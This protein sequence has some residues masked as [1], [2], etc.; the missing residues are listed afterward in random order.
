MCG[1]FRTLQNIAK[2]VVLL[3]EEHFCDACVLTPQIIEKYVLEG[4]KT[5]PRPPKIEAAATPSPK[6][7]TNMSQKCA[8]SV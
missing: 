8:R 6:K 2:T 4:S 7:T 3:H 1:M 5:L